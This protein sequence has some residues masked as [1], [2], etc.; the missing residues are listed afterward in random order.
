M[1]NSYEKDKR[2]TVFVELKLKCDIYQKWF[3]GKALSVNLKRLR[4]EE[5]EAAIGA[6]QQSLGAA[7]MGSIIQAGLLFNEAPKSIKKAIRSVPLPLPPPLPPP[8]SP[9]KNTITSPSEPMDVD[10]DEPLDSPKKENKPIF[11]PFHENYFPTDLISQIFTY[12]D[13]RSHGNLETC[14]KRLLIISRNPS[15]NLFFG[16]HFEGPFYSDEYVDKKPLLSLSR[17]S[18]LY[19]NCV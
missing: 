1:S 7:L 14:N 9:P 18:I 15:S 12:L 3:L 17:H 6:L 8:P 13:S 4:D 2:S 11:S 5:L 16:C 19:P 10:G